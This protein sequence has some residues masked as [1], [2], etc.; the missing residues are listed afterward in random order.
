MQTKHALYV[1][2]LAIIFC[3][4]DADGVKEV[5]SQALTDADYS[6]KLHAF[7]L[8]HKPG[9]F[10]VYLDVMGEEF[11]H[12]SIPHIGGKD[13]E[14]LLERKCKSLL[15]SA[16]LTWKKHLRR[17]KKGR[18]D[19]VYLIVGLPLPSSVEHVFDVLI[20]SN[21]IV[22]GVYSMSIL[23]REIEAILPVSPQNLVVSR[24]LGSPAGRKVY[25]QTFFKDGEL[26]M[27]R[28]TS[29]NGE[30]HEQIFS[31]LIGEIE[32]MHHFLAGTRQINNELTLDVCTTLGV[33]E[34]EQ[35][36]MH[37]SDSDKVDISDFHLA[38]IASKKSLKESTFSSLAELLVALAASKN[39]TPHFKPEGLC[40]SFNRV[41]AKRGM[42]AIAISVLALS[43]TVSGFFA[44]TASTEKDKLERL[45]VELAQLGEQKNTLL[46]NAQ[47]TEV[48]PAKMKQVVD[49]Y[50]TI[51]AHQYVPDDV[52]EVLSNAYKG[53]GDISLIK[54]SWLKP[55]GSEE[56]NNRRRRANSEPF[57]NT[58]KPTR[59]FELKVSLPSKLSNRMILE[60]MTDFSTALNKQPEITSVTREKAALDAGAN[61]RL[62]ES[63]GGGMSNK[64]I[65]FTLLIEMGLS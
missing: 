23:A 46:D 9:A 29:I 8:R 25:R 10:S 14:L 5:F 59:Q 40:T 52:L 31:Q 39:L 64:P 63:L 56:Q 58:L 21:Q 60:R 28:V 51:H 12:E 18:K 47:V 15:S 4:I 36:A 41:K 62:S 7:L 53:F 34:T 35:L 27:S 44:F 20:Q 2:D 37:Q 43:I 61:A 57:L 13:R 3:D 42:N 30:T 1:T 19:D 26:A 6:E 17:E 54:L 22:S 45:I 50:K 48:E 11:K 65:E 32:R 16:D 55:Q 38:D 49:L 24:V 33:Q